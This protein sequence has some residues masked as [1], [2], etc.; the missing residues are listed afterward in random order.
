MSGLWRVV[1]STLLAAGCAHLTSAL[2]GQSPYDVLARVVVGAADIGIGLVL[3]LHPQW[4]AASVAFVVTVVLMIE[5]LAVMTAHFMREDHDG[6]LWLL[7]AGF[8]S[9]LLGLTV[10]ALASSRPVTFVAA[11]V[12]INFVVA[13]TTQIAAS[14][15]TQRLTEVLRP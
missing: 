12:G 9:A 2:R 11:I 6:S 14:I 15:G 4:G 8:V 5:G 10:M 7:S 1:A 13:G 3:M